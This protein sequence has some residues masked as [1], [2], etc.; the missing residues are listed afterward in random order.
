MVGTL[1][2]VSAVAFEFGFGQFV[3]R[4]VL[5]GSGLTSLHGGFPLV[6]M[7]VMMFSPVVV[8]TDTER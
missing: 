4:V 8:L 1:W 5:G 7:A 6:V 2:T 3:F